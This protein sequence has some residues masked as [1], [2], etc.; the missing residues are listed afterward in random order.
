MVNRASAPFDLAAIGR[1]LA[2]GPAHTQI[3]RRLGDAV[4]AP[5]VIQAPPGSGKTTIVPPT[6]ANALAAA[7]LG[8]RVIV[9]QPRRM[10]A[11]A[12]A[13]RLAAKWQD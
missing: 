7:R 4:D 12:A 10:A 11:R 3:S 5:L 13:R 9:T 2:F 1:G 8:G 6:V